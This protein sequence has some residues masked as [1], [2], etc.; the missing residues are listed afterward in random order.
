M[1][2]SVDA[3]AEDAASVA[4]YGS[5]ASFFSYGEVSL[6]ILAVATFHGSIARWPLIQRSS[7]I[8]F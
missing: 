7:E 4:S 8:C 1:H 2:L 5:T 6:A 3:G